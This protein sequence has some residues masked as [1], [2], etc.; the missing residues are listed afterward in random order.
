MNTQDIIQE[1]KT[2]SL[3]HL[4]QTTYDADLVESVREDI[5]KLI[6]RLDVILAKNV[7]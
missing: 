6:Q 2:H 4:K 5:L 7:A 3:N 1:I